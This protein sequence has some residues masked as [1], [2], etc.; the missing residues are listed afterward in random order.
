MQEP[1]AIFQPMQKPENT[2]YSRLIRPAIHLM[3]R[4]NYTGRSL[5]LGLMTTVAIFAVA[6]SLF[7]NL[8]QVLRTAQL[9][10]TGHSLLPPVSRT[11]RLL[12]Q[13]RGRSASVLSG[14][15]TMRDALAVQEA[16][17]AKAFT[18]ME[19]T[20]PAALTQSPDFQDIKSGWLRLETEGLSWTLANNFAEHSR[21]IEALL[22]FMASI[23]DNY[24]LTS[25]SR[26]DSYYMVRTSLL[27][28][29]MAIERMGQLRAYGSAIV[30]A[31]QLSE[32]QKIKLL[33]LINGLQ[34]AQ[35]T[36]TVN[37]D[38][39]GYFNPSLQDGLSISS[40]EINQAVQQIVQLVESEIIRQ[41]FSISPE[42]FFRITT[43]KIDGLYGLIDQDFTTASFALIQ[44]RIE[45]TRTTLY[46]SIG[47][48]AALLT[49]VIYFSIG[50][51]YSTM[52]SIRDLA[53]AARRFAD[54]DLQQRVHL[55]THDEL[56]QIGDSFNEMAAGFSALLIAR[57]ED[58]MRM[59][60]II[61]TALDAIIQIDKNG[62]ITAWNPTATSMFGWDSDEVLGHPL[63][64]III[65]SRYRGNHLQGLQHFLRNSDSKR[66][67]R[68]METMAVHKQGHEFPIELAISINRFNKKV[69]FCAFIRDISERVQAEAQLTTLST[70]I[71]Q[72]PTTIFIT[73]A[74]GIIEYVNPHFTKITGYSRE[75][76]QGRNP[77]FLKSGLVPQDV[78]QELWETISQGRIWQGDVV[79]RRKDGSL[80]W[81]NTHIAPV[82]TADGSIS[83]YVAIKLDVT[84][85]IRIEQREKYRARVLELLATGASLREVLNVLI[86]SM[87]AA[88]PG[89]R[90]SIL[91]LDQSGQHLLNAAAP[92]LP[93]FYVAAVDKLAIG[94]C[95]GSCG[96]AAY[97]GERVI[98]AD[99]QS[100]PNWEG[101]KTLAAEA[102]LASCW[103]EPIRSSNGKVL[104]TLA[105]YNE[106]IGPPDAADIELLEYGA[107]LAGIAI[108]KHQADE[109]LQLAALVY[110]NS[111]EAMI[112]T[113]ADGM[114]L[115]TNPAFSLLTGYSRD[116]AL[117]RNPNFLGSGIHSKT[118]YQDMW[119]AIQDTG[120]WRGEIWN[121]NKNGDLYIEELTINTIFNADN[122]AQRRVA[123]F[124]DITQ[125]K[126]SEE[127]IWR[128]ANF[129]PL[130]GLP[131][132]SMFREQLK[133]EIKKAHRSGQMLAVFFLD[134]DRFKEVND[135]QGHEM[136]DALLKEAARR[137][138][139]C[140][141]ET[142]TAAR[143]GGDE[144]TLILTDLGSIDSLERIAE[145][146]LKQMAE[147][148]QLG[149]EQ[150]FISA[151]IG[152][153]LYPQDAGDIEQLLKNADQAMYTSKRLGRSRYSFFTSAMQEQTLLRSKLINDLRTALAEQ[154]FLVAYQPI[155]ELASGAIHKAEALIRWQHPLRGFINP[156]DFI[157][158][159]EESGLINDIGEWIFAEACKQVAIW[160]RTHHAS[161]QI[162][163]NKSPVQIK[164]RDKDHPAWHLQLQKQG[165]PGQSIVVEITE[166]LLLDADPSTQEHLLSLR[167][168]GIEVAIDDFGTG[169]SSLAYLKKFDIDYLKIDQSFTRELASGSDALVLCEAIIA[170]AHKL[171]LKVIAEGVETEQ[172]RRLLLDCD[173]DYAQGYL[174]AHPM[175]A[176]D[177]DRFLTSS[178]L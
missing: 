135:S 128:Q 31:K 127:N 148:F 93:D 105:F 29:P 138:S 156:I 14:N 169:Y 33:T 141:R 149:E 39:I 167:A 151:S 165:L 137:L 116:E 25:D 145:D 86:Y 83:H 23:G 70:A 172:Q 175:L 63:H 50:I 123:L 173:C 35:K 108:Q 3:S 92:G 143:L 171:G 46:A 114:I 147:P 34:D 26:L 82:K 62:N 84:E 125:R 133:H 20:L 40:R 6:F 4:L 75:E 170:M 9:A 154:Q 42:D 101:F 12:Q 97:T 57:Q 30:T 52:I 146:I 166:G 1:P 100:H 164:N 8:D 19:K 73:D 44:N 89:K 68:R 24:K 150:T 85:R 140:V 106:V 11:V 66:L 121:R 10:L 2:Q 71:E 161:F 174:F 38:K 78:Y 47:I 124:S 37:L 112:V 95:V 178:R 163:V 5:L 81:E 56:R 139:A 60:A 59:S 88:S 113:D 21:L 131:N 36:L 177:F 54:G 17:T 80:Y 69:E 79:N 176:E 18:A 130:T 142:D 43:Q 90:G 159:S 118:F 157:P 64:E 45:H 76:A 87:E 22:N 132:R 110:R 51:Y 96:A 134:L 136:G 94:P 7:I 16:E 13:H 117:G 153:T 49:L 58:G 152:I 72:S 126:Q 48:A 28:L 67:N 27:E 109:A 99:I 15:V 119:R 144:F 102:G 98:V 158:V 61:D 32:E 41:R 107:H 115:D 65:P 122:S 160:R 129:D 91:L 111:S 74:N 104:G 162:S 168:A 103:S 120:H 155:V 55:D 77:N 53:T